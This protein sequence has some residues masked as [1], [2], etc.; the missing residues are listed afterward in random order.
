MALQAGQVA[1][2]AE[3]LPLPQLPLP[4]LFDA[5]LGPAEVDQLAAELLDGIGKLDMGAEPT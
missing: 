3:T 1:R 4:Y 2:L 5:D